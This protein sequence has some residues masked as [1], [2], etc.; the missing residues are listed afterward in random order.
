MV[1]TMPGLLAA[2][3]AA[4]FHTTLSADT[5]AKIAGTA[6]SGV[7]FCAGGGCHS[8]QI[9]PS[10]RCTAAELSC[11]TGLC[12][13]APTASSA[14]AVV[15]LQ[16]ATRTVGAKPP[17]VWR[18]RSMPVLLRTYVSGCSS[19]SWVD[20]AATSITSAGNL[21]LSYTL[22]C[23]NASK[24]WVTENF[25]AGTN[26][27]ASWDTTLSSSDDTLWTSTMGHDYWLGFNSSA[28]PLG[29]FPGAGG[30]DFYPRAG[31]SPFSPWWLPRPKPKAG[32]EEQE[33]E[34]M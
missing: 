16:G 1:P 9:R 19:G 22:T 29:W 28:P 33:R 12:V 10:A 11:V 4:A 13:A 2:A 25:G 15:A 23:A 32:P 6:C 17:I 31:Y 34:A 14:P 30:K 26:G 18:T 21:S 27:S 5:A 24:L 20:G 8:L 3:C 7:A